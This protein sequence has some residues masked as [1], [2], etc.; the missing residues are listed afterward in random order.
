MQYS[1]VTQTPAPRGSTLRVSRHKNAYFH[2]GQGIKS[3]RLAGEEIVIETTGGIRLATDFLILGTGFTVDPLARSELDGYADE[4]ELWRDRYRPPTGEE[5]NDLGNFPYLN[6]DFTFREREPG[7]APWLDKIYCFNYG[8]SASL[9]KVSGDIPGISEGAAWLA[10]ALAARLYREDVAAHFQ[11][12]L[13]YD[14]PELQG[15]EWTESDLE[16]DAVAPLQET[17]D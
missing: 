9:G 7:K 1:F 11:G 12:M 8:A 2:F 6:G 15:D 4:I 13:D 5:S 10:R 14:R 17:G 16:A 3:A